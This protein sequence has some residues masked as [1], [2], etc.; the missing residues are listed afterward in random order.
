MKYGMGS[1][2]EGQSPEG[3]SDRP[4][5]SMVSIVERSDVSSSLEG[6]WGSAAMCWD[7]RVVMSEE[8]WEKVSMRVGS[9]EKSVEMACV[10]RRQRAPEGVVSW[11][12][13]GLAKGVAYIGSR[14]NSCPQGLSSSS[15][16]QSLASHS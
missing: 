9:A 5:L 11:R 14:S 15:I 10:S 3:K 7:E 8:S 6:L 1:R 16:L 13:S 12:A 4:F 2:W